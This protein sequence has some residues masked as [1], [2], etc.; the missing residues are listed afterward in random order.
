MSLL[1]HLNCPVAWVSA[2]LNDH[3]AEGWGNPQC[4]I[5]GGGSVRQVQLTKLLGLRATPES[6]VEEAC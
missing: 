6:E 1:G 3:R 2:H 5:T 4:L